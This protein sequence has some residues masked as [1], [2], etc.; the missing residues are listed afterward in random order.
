M[1]RSTVPATLARLLGVALVASGVG[2]HFMPVQG[3]RLFG[4]SNATPEMA[5]F[6]PA[7]GSRNTALGLAVLYMSSSGQKRGVRILLG[8]L[9]AIGLADARLCWASGQTE[10]MGV[11]IINAVLIGVLSWLSP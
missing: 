1:A 8:S 3:A 2:L 5:M 6:V 11:H 10:G 7:M 9:A 4:I